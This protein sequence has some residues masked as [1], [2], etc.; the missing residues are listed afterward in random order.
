MSNY[1]NE[2]SSLANQ[3]V[4]QEVFKNIEEI[5]NNAKKIV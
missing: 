4:M 5:S 2:I 1:A 3:N